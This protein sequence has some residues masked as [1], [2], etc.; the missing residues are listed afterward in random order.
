MLTQAWSN[1][2]MAR[3]TQGPLVSDADR[4][5][6]MVAGWWETFRCAATVSLTVGYCRTQYRTIHRTYRAMLDTVGAFIFVCL[7]NPTMSW[8]ALTQ[9]DSDLTFPTSLQTPLGWN[10][11]IWWNLYKIRIRVILGAKLMEWQCMPQFSW[12]H[13]RLLGARWTF[14][15]AKPNLKEMAQ[16]PRTPADS[17]QTNQSVWKTNLAQKST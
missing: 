4:R 12:L 8:R 1:G 5:R 3:T 13:P 9:L 15:R 2:H 11:E 10:V 6:S 7:S 14:G 17:V 16:K